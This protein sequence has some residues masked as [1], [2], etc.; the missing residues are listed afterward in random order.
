MAV[1]YWIAQFTRRDRRG[2]HAQGALSRRPSSPATRLGGQS[3]SADIDAAAGDRAR[4][5]RD[6]LPR[7]R[8]VRHRG[9]SDAGR[10]SAASRSVSRSTADILAIGPL[11]GG[12]MNPARSFGPAVVTHVFEGQTAYWV[13]PLLGGIVAALL[14]DRLFLRDATPSSRRPRKRLRSRRR[15]PTAVSLSHGRRSAPH[16]CRAR[17]SRRSASSRSTSRTTICRSRSSSDGSSRS[18]RRRASPSSRRSRPTCASR[19][20]RRRRDQSSAAM[21]N[22]RTRLRDVESRRAEFTTPRRDERVE[23]D[24]PVARAAA[25]RRRRR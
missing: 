4:G 13:G 7:L 5:D 22:A 1:V 23:A 25:P 18:T 10:R 9:R 21:S 17:A 15:R 11:T 2:V 24:G 6:V 3:I 12:S 19:R 8:R 20:S 16:R 14:Y